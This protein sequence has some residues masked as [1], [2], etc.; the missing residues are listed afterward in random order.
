MYVLVPI[1]EY[2]YLKVAAPNAIMYV[3]THSHLNGY[4]SLKEMSG[5]VGRNLIPSSL[6]FFNHICWQD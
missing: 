2:M 1:G 4:G 5:L 6:I 3:T